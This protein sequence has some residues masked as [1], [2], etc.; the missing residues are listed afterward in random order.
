M[1]KREMEMNINAEG[2]SQDT[3]F[4]CNKERERARAICTDA[5]CFRVVLVLVNIVRQFD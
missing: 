1:L 2:L 4:A 5:E 3:L